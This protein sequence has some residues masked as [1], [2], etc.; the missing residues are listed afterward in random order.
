[1]QGFLYQDGLRP[2]AEL[3]GTGAVVSRFVFASHSNVPD[4][5]IKGG[6]TYR[7][8]ADQ[9]GS[10]R[11][12]VRVDDGTVAQRLDY[13][14]FGKVS[15]DTQPGFQPFGFAGGLYDPLTGLV[16][17]GTREYD[18]ETGRWTTK[19]PIGFGGGDGNLYGYVLNDP[20]NWSDPTGLEPYRLYPTQEAAARAAML[21]LWRKYFVRGK[22]DPDNVAPTGGMIWK[23]KDGY[24]YQP[25][26]HRHRYGRFCDWQRAEVS[27]VYNYLPSNSK[28]LLRFPAS[29][30]EIR[31]YWFTSDSRVVVNVRERFTEIEDEG[32]V[33][34]TRW[35]WKDLGNLVPITGGRS[36]Q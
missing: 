34:T 18:P 21:D 32:R 28:R 35:R 5:L 10:P 15:T 7:I 14:A 26:E 25:E 19:D 33:T 2:I 20:V 8:V 17:F 22:Y 11:L 27:A 13:D 36:S 3:D 24:F 30:D 29:T 31:S 4:Y 12:V 23:G 1:V 9:L 6:V 16:H